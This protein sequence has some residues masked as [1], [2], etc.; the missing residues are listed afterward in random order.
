M[1]FAYD[2]SVSLIYFIE[3]YYK[4]NDSAEMNKK[5]AIKA[6]EFICNH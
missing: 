4:R 5:R 3:I 2:K 6:C 1:I